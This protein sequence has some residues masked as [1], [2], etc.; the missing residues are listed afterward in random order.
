MCVARGDHPQRTPVYGAL[1]IVAAMMAGLTVQY[2]THPPAAVRFPVLVLALI[3][4]IVGVGM[5][6]RDNT[7]PRRR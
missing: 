4:A 6:L 1:L 2:W 5:T 3:A 7:P